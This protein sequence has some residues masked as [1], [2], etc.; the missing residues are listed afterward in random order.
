MPPERKKHFLSLDAHGLP[1]VLKGDFFMSAGP[2]GVQQP[3][4]GI[5]GYSFA[6]KNFFQF[7][8]S[9]RIEFVKN[10]R[11]ALDQGNLHTEAG[12]E[13]GELNGD[14]APTKNNQGVGKAF[15]CEGG[16]AG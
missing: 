3:G 5:N 7:R 6:A 1:I 10:M 12:K 16:V 4:A 11:A 9:V 15:E 13:L 2:F 14:G 8:G